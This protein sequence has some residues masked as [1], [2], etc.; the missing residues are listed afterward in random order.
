MVDLEYIDSGGVDVGRSD[1][2]I[3]A[4]KDNGIWGSGR[5]CGPKLNIGWLNGNEFPCGSMDSPL[6]SS[7]AENLFIV[8]AKSE[9]GWGKT[10]VSNDDDG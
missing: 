10:V 3:L 5:A 6:A 9:A 7:S 2:V 1:S 4:S 8:S